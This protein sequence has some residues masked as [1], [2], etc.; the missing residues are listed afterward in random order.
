MYSALTHTHSLLRWIALLAIL[1]ALF[2]ALSGVV[3][4]RPFSANDNRWSL[5]TVITF[6]LQLVIGLVLYFTEG[7]YQKWGEMADKSVR[8]FAVEHLLGMLVVIALVTIGRASGKRAASDLQ[9]HRRH[10]TYFLLALLL[11][12]ANIPWPFREIIGAGKSWFPGM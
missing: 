2:N 1:V 6:H 11:A 7:W 10:F 4:K 8:F 12:V 9:K 3:K 5:I